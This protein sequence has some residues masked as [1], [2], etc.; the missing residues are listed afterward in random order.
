MFFK[1]KAESRFQFAHSVD[2][3][4]SCDWDEIE[5]PAKIQDLIE[6]N[7][8]TL[9]NSISNKSENNNSGYILNQMT[10]TLDLK[11]LK[12][13]WLTKKE[14][15]LLKNERNTAPNMQSLESPRNRVGTQQNEKTY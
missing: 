8:R 11:E 12:E 7:I 15:F 5:V 10:N 9:S 4:K 2:P 13:R 1:K 14:Y 3:I 6:R